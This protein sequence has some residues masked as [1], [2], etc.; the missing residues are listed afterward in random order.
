MDRKP[1]PGATSAIALVLVTLI[2]LPLVAGFFGRL[3]PAFDSFA[4]FRV[5]LAVLLIVCALPLLLGAFRREGLAA[6][7]F[8]LAAIT[9]V[10]GATFLPGLRPAHAAFAPRDDDQPVYRLLQMNLRFDN[11]EPEKVLSLIAPGAARRDHA[12]TKCPTCGRRRSRCSMPPIPTGW[13]A[14]SAIMPAAWRSCRSG[15][16]PTAPKAAASTAAPSRPRHSTSAAGRS[17]SRALHLHWPWPFDQSA[18][19]DEIAGDLAGLP[20]DGAA[21]RRS[22]RH[23]VE[24]R[25]RADRRSRR[26]AAGR[27]D[28]RRPGTTACCRNSCASPACRSTRSSPRATFSCIRPGRSSRGIRP[29]AGAGRVLA[30]RQGSGSRRGSAVDHRATGAE[31][32]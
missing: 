13:S 32:G 1:V 21:C 31:A 25:R 18:Q 16:S 27:P 9:T 22:Q 24:R 5:H 2:S 15:P 8:G 6:I 20:R 30:A 29:P 19:I 10:T 17:R 23:A 26:A 11:R 3:H 7:A 12:R 4:H 28:R 14:R